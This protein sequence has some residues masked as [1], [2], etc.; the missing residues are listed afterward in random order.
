MD[1]HKIIVRVGGHLRASQAWLVKW[2]EVHVVTMTRTC[3]QLPAL[4]DL[5][6]EPGF[7]LG[8]PQ[9]KIYYII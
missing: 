8:K 1:S 6:L 5:M 3:V 9:H 2:P 7:Q 4:G